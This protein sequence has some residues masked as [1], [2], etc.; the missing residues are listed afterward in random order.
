M[1]T[2]KITKPEQFEL[3][4]ESLINRTNGYNLPQSR[5]V[6]KILTLF[7]EKGKV[8]ESRNGID[9]YTP[10]TL[11]LLFSI[12]DAHFA[13]LYEVFNETIWTGLGT[14]RATSVADW[15]DEANKDA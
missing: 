7:E 10:T 1:K 6:A 3:V 8:K 9:L 4:Y 11:P 14:R 15:L 5:M 12:E 2:L 13:L